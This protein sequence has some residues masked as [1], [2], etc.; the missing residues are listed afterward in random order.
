MKKQVT[1][2]PWVHHV[3][4]DRHAQVLDTIRQMPP[5]S[6]LALEI[7]RKELEY[8]VTFISSA[9]INFQ[10]LST[11]KHLLENHFHIKYANLQII[12][13]CINRRIKIIPIE[14]ETLQGFAVS[15][16]N[17]SQLSENERD[18]KFQQI[19]YAREVHF[20]QELQRLL[21]SREQI[22][23]LTG[24]YHTMPLYNG[25]KDEFNININPAM[26]NSKE[27]MEEYFRRVR[28]FRMHALNK[29]H[30]EMQKAREDLDNYS[31]ENGIYDLRRPLTD[32]HFYRM[33]G[34]TLHREE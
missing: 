26:F 25:L 11:L 34:G 24:A 2:I 32:G 10:G 12:E 14:D 13:A 9:T 22:F 21:N 30:N 5:N 8:V 33:I 17:N 29:N 16:L 23:V 6:A 27:E 4:S 20:I 28:L 7:T 1:L 3:K 15:I 31:R 19:N 18:I